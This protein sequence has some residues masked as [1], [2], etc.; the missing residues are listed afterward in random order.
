M[1]MPQYVLLNNVAHKN[2]RVI[3]RYGD[4]FGDNTGT[5]VIFPTEFEYVQREYPIFFRKDPER[6]E[7]QSIALLG[8]DKSENLYVKDGKWN[9][10]Y[11][12]A[13][14]SRGPFMIGFQE[15]EVD[16]EKRKNPVIHV[17]MEHLRVSQTEGEP[18]FTQSGGNSAYL[19]RVAGALGAIGQGL[20]IS[21][22]MFAA[23]TELNLIEPMNLNVKPSPDESY[24]LVGLHS[25]NQQK[26]MELDGASLERLNRAGFLR[27]AYLVSASID[28][29]KR[30]MAFK[31]IK[32]AQ[33]ES[34]N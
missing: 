20:E 14:V 31:Q 8:F 6:D 10:N 3:N 11:V 34:A 2:L 7:Y 5:V 21:K 18:V 30:L 32:R 13:V 23:F 22:V 24:S 4:E 26:L 16:G 27:A 33:S 25:I 19:D 12:P 15:R 9:A 29:V 1:N 28:N 17:D